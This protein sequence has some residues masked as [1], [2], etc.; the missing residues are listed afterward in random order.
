[1][2]IA[3]DATVGGA[4]ANAYATVPAAETAASYRVGGNAAAWLAL[5][6]DQ[7]IQTLVTA[8]RD[9][10]TVTFAGARASSTQALEWPR[11]GTGYSSTLL[12]APLV[13]ATIELAL[14]YARV[15][16][17]GATETDVLTPSTASV[18]REQVGSVE[19]EYF[20]PA[21]PAVNALAHFPAIVQRLL[22]PLV[23]QATAAGW[24]SSRVVRSS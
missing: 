23:R 12:P 9:I 4:S 16:A 17:P 1:M 11:T 3:L 15:F 14:S 6:P 18:K 24:G 5:T 20:T 10:D 22:W 21:T 13:A 8:T 19:V 2:P 7:K